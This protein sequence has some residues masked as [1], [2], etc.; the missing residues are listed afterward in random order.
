ME[1]LTHHDG[2]RKHIEVPVVY[3][4]R[5]SIVSRFQISPVSELARLVPGY[6]SA[7][8]IVGNFVSRAD[9]RGGFY[10]RLTEVRLARA[11]YC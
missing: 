10:F 3:V 2:T 4:N 7:V 1:G 9:C 5:L 6:L 11:K 8:Q